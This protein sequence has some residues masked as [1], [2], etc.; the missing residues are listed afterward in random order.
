MDLLP[1]DFLRHSPF[2]LLGCCVTHFVQTYS[3]VDRVAA[4]RKS[5][6]FQGDIPP[7]SQVRFIPYREGEAG[8]LVE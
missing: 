3:Q 8:S 6:G 1:S 7:W 2:G 5:V 4:C